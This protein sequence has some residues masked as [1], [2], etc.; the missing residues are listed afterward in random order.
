VAL[1]Q[2]WADGNYVLAL[3]QSFLFQ[4][5]IVGIIMGLIG[6]IRK[7]WLIVCS[8]FCACCLI[9]E[10]VH[11]Y[12][13]V[14]AIDDSVHELLIGTFNVYHHNNEIDGSIAT[15]INSNCD[16][17]SIIE[18]NDEF[19]AK[20]LERVSLS[21]PYSISVPS[22]V[23]CYGMA[24]YSKLPIVEDSVYYWTQDPV[25]RARIVSAGREVDVWSVH[26]RPP[27]FP[28]DTEERN[29]LMEKVAEEI[30]TIGKPALLAGDLNIV[31]WD[32]DFKQM[33]TTSGMNDSRRGFLATYPMELGI[34]L[35]P[36]D[37]I[38]HTEHFTTAY[39]KTQVIPGS[40]HK[41]LVAGLDWKQFPN[42]FPPK[43]ARYTC[44]TSFR[45]H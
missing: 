9:A 32:E 3:L 1:T 31:P 14:C 17:L 41:A 19:N 43:A 8:S 42:K 40:D 37:H 21:H 16:L 7:W 15:I 12:L 29:Y 28:N 35:I 44:L 22:P 11:P 34:P 39:C 26:T 18:V 4:F 23:C 38:M 45:E 6:I 2:K 10:Q 30:K 24:F 20:M 36:I 5:L 27:I 13:K 33:K 25:I